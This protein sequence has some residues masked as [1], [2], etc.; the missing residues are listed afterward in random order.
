MKNYPSRKKNSFISFVAFEDGTDE[1]TIRSSK[2]RRR[3][4]RKHC[5]RYIRLRVK[6]TNSFNE[7]ILI[8]P[9]VLALLGDNPMQSEFACHI[10]LRGRLFCRACWVEGAKGIQKSTPGEDSSDGASEGSA[11]PDP[12]LVIPELDSPSDA[13][14]GSD[15][16]SGVSQQT[17]NSGRSI[18]VRIAEGF[19]GLLAR[20]KSFI[21]VC[22][23]LFILFSY[24]LIDIK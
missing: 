6:I 18:A 2:V 17:S 13:E 19:D 10:G 11:G 4:S 5:S 15:A 12:D 24:C 3:Q 1:T 14:I 8:I 23:I 20:L 7:P 21:K 9:F 16:G 22:V